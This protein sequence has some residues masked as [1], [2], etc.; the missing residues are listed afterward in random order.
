MAFSGPRNS[1]K[2]AF[3]GP[4]NLQNGAL[5]IWPQKEPKWGSFWRPKTPKSGDF[6]PQK[7]PKLHEWQ[8]G[9]VFEGGDSNFLN[10]GVKQRLPWKWSKSLWN[11]LAQ[12]CAF[13]L[14]F[15]ACYYYYSVSSVHV[16]CHLFK[17]LIFRPPEMQNINVNVSL[18]GWF[19]LIFNI[20]E[21]WGILWK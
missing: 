16:D 13:G 20:R 10:I 19:W 12:G 14:V 21:D 2:M 3:S 8:G 9:G 17:L 15:C 5:S 7:S 1:Q 4:R 6:W 18:F 11:A